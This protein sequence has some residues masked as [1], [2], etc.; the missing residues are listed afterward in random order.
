MN[1]KQKL[2]LS[3]AASD[4]AFQAFGKNYYMPW[5]DKA[6]FNPAKSFM[7]SAPVDAGNAVGKAAIGAGRSLGKS[8]LGSKGVAAVGGV[9]GGGAKGVSR[10][11]PVQQEQFKKNVGALPSSGVGKTM[12]QA[13]AKAFSPFARPDRM[14][15]QLGQS[16]G[17]ALGPAGGS[18]IDSIL[19]GLDTTLLGGPLG[20]AAKVP[21][22]AGVGKGIRSGV[23]KTVS[24][25]PAMMPM[26]S[27]R[28]A[29]MR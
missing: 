22:K 17:K 27:P 15:P 23:G 12:Q 25:A 7:A 13:A 9:L 19:N 24:K 29:P 26:P 6:S 1:N 14:M 11:G 8:L 16:T 18:S 28:P 5:Q 4:P 3:K 10:G 2:Y 21:L 20:R